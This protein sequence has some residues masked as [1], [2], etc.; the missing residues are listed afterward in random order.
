MIFRLALRSLLVHPVRSAVLA[1][2]FG[3]GVSVMATLL[4]VGDVILEQARSPALVGSGDLLVT[5][6]AGS[7]SSARFVLSNVLQTRPLQG[8]VA[9]ASPRRRTRLF[10]VHENRVLPIVAKGGVPSLERALGDPETATLPAWMDAPADRA[11]SAPDAGDV[12][13]GLDRFHAIPDVPARAGSWAEWLYFNGQAGAA[14]FYATFL[15][16]PRRPDGR[17]NAG[18]RLQL[19]RGG[20]R[21]SY[22]EGAV[23]DEAEL[24]SDAPDLAIGKSSVR[25]RGLRYE[26]HLDLAQESGRGHVLATVSLE[27][28]RGRAVP[29]LII[30]GAGGWLSGYVVPVMSGGLGGELAVDGERVSLEGG[31]GYHDHNWGFWEGVTWR[32]G[33]VHHEGLSFVYGRVYPPADAADPDRVPGFLAALGP[34]GPLGYS[35]Q[36]T[37]DEQNDA[38]RPGRIVVHGK[39]GSLDVKMALTVEDVVATRMG[40]QFFGGGMDL[41]QLRAS[42]R[43]TGAVAGRVID[44]TAKGSAET[45]R[46]R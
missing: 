35:T 36:L 14:R 31:L 15:V 44:F 29:P 43:V 1:S 3:L 7:L 23:V 21:A 40:Q 12:L 38:G 10:L 16:G 17:R 5:G 41:L 13:R 32:W 33:Q 45:F 37:I 26:L 18:V 30:R 6:V 34:D 4:G 11:W 39:S 22:S 27:A 20:R 42:Y 28:A 24:L 19:D 2:G 9:A 8:R 25:L 46:G